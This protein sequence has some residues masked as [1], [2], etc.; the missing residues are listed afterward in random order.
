MQL[1]NLGENRVILVKMCLVVIWKAAKAGSVGDNA[2]PELSLCGSEFTVWHKVDT[3]W[4]CTKTT[5]SVFDT[6]YTPPGAKFP[7]AEVT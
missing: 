1:V 6:E 4:Q 5:G 3:R 7:N 2:Q